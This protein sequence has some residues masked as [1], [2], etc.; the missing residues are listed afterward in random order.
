MP[1]P[2]PKAIFLSYARDDA[3]AA[4]RV[5]EALRSSGLEVWFDE[6]ELRGGDTWDAKI[7]KQIDACALFIPIVS[8]TTESRAKGY[9]RLEWNLATAQTQMLA[10]GVP[11][12]APV[13][14][15]ETKEY[16]ASVPA[17]FLKV[18]WM[19]LPG[20]LPTPQF[21]EQVKRLL[22][23]PIKPA[24]KARIPGA[25]ESSAAPRGGLS[26]WVWAAA[27]AVIG[28]VVFFATRPST[29]EPEP[30]TASPK[31]AATATTATTAAPLSE[32]RQLVAK[33]RALYEPW[34]LASGEDFALAEQLLKK[35]VQL[36][37]ADGEAWA[38]YAILSCAY[39]VTGR[40]S[41]PQERRA[42]ARTQADRA[43]KLAPESDAA[44]FAR[45]FSLRFNLATR[46]E[47]IR[48]LREEAARQPNNRLV[49]RILGTTLGSARQFEQAL[50]FIDRAVALPGRDPVTLYNRAQYLGILSRFVEAEATIDEV[51]ALAPNYPDANA[52]KIVL[53][54]DYHGDLA[55]AQ[56]HVGKFSPD[57][58]TS[59]S[60]ASAAAIVWLYARE[61]KMAIEALRPA[62]EYLTTISYVG[63]KALLTG[64]A[65]RM[66][67]NADAA[68]TDWRAALH[69]VDQRLTSQPND[70]ELLKAK[71]GLLAL[72]GE[73]AQFDPL[74]REL[75]QR[76][77]TGGVSRFELAL[78][79]SLAD[80]TEDALTALEAA[81]QQKLITTSAS[82]R[83]NSLRYSPEWDSLRGN[84]RF[85]A[86]LKA[87]EQK[88]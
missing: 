4:R 68:R 26:P 40:D 39:A 28:G 11:F 63:P 36:D 83:R 87:P 66:A 65:Q 44:R 78:L 41:S 9:F 80:M 52:M 43:I 49:V 7:R 37:P 38:S 13:V 47:A 27:V 24:T 73:R 30:P 57:F 2:A 81:A 71:A 19:R 20:A 86:L 32:A 25:P 22:E 58:F 64:F 23:A 88:K 70:V 60:G 15:D 16:G 35:A 61:S 14:I 8:Q 85:E 48:L 45:A 79:F 10:E 31:P 18:Q 46:D 56:R 74:L 77:E 29:K 17:E 34:D 51:L 82:A 33:A 59:D 54:L 84:P 62:H 12:I 75:Q 6:N 55:A 69:V 3:A 53:L 42:A 1:D 50:L 5:A 67:G 72:L 21:V 76:M